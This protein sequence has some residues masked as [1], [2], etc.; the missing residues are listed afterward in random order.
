MGVTAEYG[1]ILARTINPPQSLVERGLNL[2]EGRG[3]SRES[4]RK[5][6]HGVAPSNRP[7]ALEG[8][9]SVTYVGGRITGEGNFNRLVHCSP[10]IFYL[11]F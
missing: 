3:I 5:T 2:L 9:N 10:F 7:A 6:R 4:L 11:N 8:G 1:W